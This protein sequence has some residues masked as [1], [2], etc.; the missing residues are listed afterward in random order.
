MSENSNE[1][2][3]TLDGDWESKEVYINGRNLSPAK[4][5]KLRNHSPDGFNW[6]Y[7]GSGPA[8]LALSVC[9]FYFSDEGKAM[10]CY[11]DFK[12][13]VIAGLPQKD[14]AVKIDMNEFKIIPNE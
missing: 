5:Q 6:G 2:V 1:S 11:Q 3:I 13:K 12:F 14:F 8:Q 10:A 7:G 9:L 4:G